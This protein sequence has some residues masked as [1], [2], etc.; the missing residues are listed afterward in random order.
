VSW[1]WISRRWLSPLTLDGWLKQAGYDQPGTLRVGVIPWT[2]AIGDAVAIVAIGILLTFAV[3][4]A[5][6]QIRQ[7]GIKPAYLPQ[8]TANTCTLDS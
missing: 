8:L 6:A 4:S 3:F 1:V 7:T 2:L 5:T